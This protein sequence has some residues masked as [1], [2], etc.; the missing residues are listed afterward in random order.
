LVPPFGLWPPAHCQG[1]RKDLMC[2][3]QLVYHKGEE[4]ASTF[5]FIFQGFSG[6]FSVHWYDVLVRAAG[7]YADMVGVQ[8]L[9]QIVREGRLPSLSNASIKIY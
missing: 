9:C 2:Y 5:S 7:S 1:T 3:G 6:F 4:K 8:A